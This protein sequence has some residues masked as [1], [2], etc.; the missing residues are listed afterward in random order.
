MFYEFPKNLSLDE[1]RNV[2]QR[3][4]EALGVTAFIEA[5]RGGIVIFKP[6]S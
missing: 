4:N 6:L 2:V 3:H 1:V 5:D